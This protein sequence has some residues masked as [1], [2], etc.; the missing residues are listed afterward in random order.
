MRTKN[1]YDQ[2]LNERIYHLNEVTS[3]SGQTVKWEP[4]AYPNPQFIALSRPEYELLYGGARGGGKTDAGMVWLL[5]DYKHPLLRSLVIRRNST[6]LTDWIDRAKRLYNGLGVKVVGNPPQFHFPSGAIFY[7][8]HLKDADAYSKYIGHEYQRVLIEELT[9]IPYEKWYLQLIS[10]C[11]STI[12]DLPARIFA[13]T[14]PG[15]AGHLWVKARFVD[16]ANNHTYLDPVTGR[17]RIF[18]PSRVDDNPVLMKMDPGYISFLDGLPPNLRKAWREGSWDIVAG[19]VFSTWSNDT[20]VCEPFSIPSDW[21]RYAAMDWGS[22]RPL[23]IAWYAEDFDGRTYKYREAYFGR[24]G[25]VAAADDFIARTG[26]EFSPDNVSIFMRRVMNDTKE[27][28]EYCTADPACFSP[29]QHDRGPSIAEEMGEDHQ[30]PETNKLLPGIPMRR[31]DND[32]IN[33]LAR[34]RQAIS[35]APDKKPW[36]VIF[37]ICTNHIRTYPALS[38][39]EVKT[40]DVNT[41]LEDHVYDMDRYHFM[42]RPFAPTHPDTKAPEDVRGTFEYH[43]KKARLKR[44]MKTNYDLL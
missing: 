24:E 44:M 41:D 21:H 32:R 9:L 19:Q 10:S 20:H 17:S 5:R 37:S 35:M 13:T 14:N 15:N 12:A 6:D 25:E 39:D 34:V 36:F 23:S 27:D 30:D 26:L 33:G 38:Y 28:I 40:D 11:R 1:F 16:V 42:S 18:I 3:L 8:G 43:L 2:R 4:F 22:N 7:T 31:G 29:R